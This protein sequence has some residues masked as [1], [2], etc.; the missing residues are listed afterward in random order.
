VMSKWLDSVQEK[1]E[2]GTFDKNGGFFFLVENA[3]MRCH[4]SQ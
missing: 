2:G 4:V 1:K 3:V